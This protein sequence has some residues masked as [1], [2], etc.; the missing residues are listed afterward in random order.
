MATAPVRRADGPDL[1]PLLV[2]P[3]GY[4]Q[5]YLA[6]CGKDYD[7]VMLAD[8]RDILFQ[9]IRSTLNGRRLVRF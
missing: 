6:E 4:Y 2:R 7:R 3:R 9:R 8:I 5:T 1:S